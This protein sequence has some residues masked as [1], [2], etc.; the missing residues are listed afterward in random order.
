MCYIVLPNELLIIAHH[1]INGIYKLTISTLLQN[2]H[3]YC[4]INTLTH[5]VLLYTNKTVFITSTSKN[6]INRENI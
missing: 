5:C 6:L 1:A 2:L 4:I 3:I